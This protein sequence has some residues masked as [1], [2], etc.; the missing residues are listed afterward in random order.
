VSAEATLSVEIS[1]KP[2]GGRS[3]APNPAGEAHS[4]PQPPSWWEGV[5]A[6][7]SRSPPPLLAFGHSVLAPIKNPDHALV[8][9]YVNT[10]TW[11]LSETLGALAPFYYAPEYNCDKLCGRP[12]QHAPA[13]AI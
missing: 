3:S 12:P 4:A 5:A 6:R 8:F 7:S 13:P 1:G 10:P 2:L 11:T 9:A